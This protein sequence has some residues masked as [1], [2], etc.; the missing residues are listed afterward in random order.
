VD[1]LAADGVLDDLSGVGHS[2][3]PCSRGVSR[4]LP[5]GTSSVIGADDDPAGS[6]GTIRDH[7]AG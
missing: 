7:V 1:A 3:A 6:R 5:A 2:G 4:R